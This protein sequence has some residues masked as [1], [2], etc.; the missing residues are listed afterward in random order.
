MSEY[1]TISPSNNSSTGIFSFSQGSNLCNFIV[2]SQGNTLVGSSVRFNGRI[3]VSGAAAG[4][5]NLNPRV[6][7]MSLIDSISISSHETGQNIETL[8]FYPRFLSSLYSTINSDDD[9]QGFMSITQS[10]AGSF[11]G[12][13]NGLGTQAVESANNIMD[14]SFAIPTG[15]FL[16]QIGIPLDKCGGLF[17]SCQL[18]NDQSLFRAD[19]GKSPVYSISDVHLSGLISNGTSNIESM[20]YNTVS[21]YYGIVNSAF[22][23]LQ[24]NLSLSKVL[25][26]WL[27][28]IPSEFTNSYLHDG[29]ATMPI[30]SNPT[31][32]VQP[33]EV[34]FLKGGMKFPLDYSIRDEY[35]SSQ[36]LFNSQITKN[37]MNA[38]KKFS[39]IGRTNITPNNSNLVRGY[40]ATSDNLSSDV[41]YGIGV[42]L[43]ATSDSGVSYLG[44]TF[45]V[46]IAS[47]LNTNYNNSAYLMIHHK[48]T[49]VFAK[50]G[51]RVLN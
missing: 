9:F 28:F 21:S 42:R 13:V 18:S 12:A 49:L 11:G 44:D 22:S 46:T 14:F 25:G 1:F 2:P 47:N 19:A 45:G 50:D 31:T 6:A 8:K 40:E 43:D 17:I 4:E 24:Y 36:T 51:L 38:V 20:T 37:Y 48:N 23:T 35:T 27:N 39:S 34:N 26:A 41:V 32:P 33:T 5:F 7:L 3:S 30:M 16:S 15:L 29:Q 10:T